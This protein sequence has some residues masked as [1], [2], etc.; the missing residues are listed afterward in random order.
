MF[1]IFIGS[2]IKNEWPNV[3]PEET[4][5]MTKREKEQR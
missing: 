3:N 2:I 5:L 4:V 1:E